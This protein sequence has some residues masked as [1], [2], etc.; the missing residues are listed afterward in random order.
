MIETALA[1]V[2]ETKAAW[3][4]PDLTRALSNALPDH[5]GHLDAEQVSRLLDGLTAEALK[6]AVP[7]D[8]GR[9]GDTVAAR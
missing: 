2:Q 9:P 8:A 3:T 4:A 5:L 1:D 6:L 7:L